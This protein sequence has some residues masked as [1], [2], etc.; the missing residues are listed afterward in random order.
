M[1][2]GAWTKNGGVQGFPMAPRAEHEEDG[3]HTNAIGSARPTAAEAV[4]V[5]V[6]WKP[7]LDFRPKF[8]GNTPMLGPFVI[9]HDHSP[10][11]Q[12]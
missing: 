6:F 4:F 11:L 5:Y 8:I 10:E 1:G 7:E 9:V 12:L 2:S 3:I